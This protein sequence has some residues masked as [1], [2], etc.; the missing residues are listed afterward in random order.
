METIKDFIKD[1]AKSLIAICVNIALVAGIGYFIYSKVDAYIEKKT[2]ESAPVVLTP[3][4]AT[5]ANYLQNEEGLK[6]EDSKVVVLEV[7]KAQ[8]GVTTPN[9][10]ITVNSTSTKEAAEEVK[11][12]IANN[13][14]TLPA[15]A[16]EK[17]DKT[18]VSEQPE[19]QEYEVG[20]YKI[21]TYRNWGIGLGVGNMDGKTYIPIAIERQYSR[22]KSIEF[23]VNYDVSRS[24]IDGG[25]IVHKWHF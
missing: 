5:N 3:E 23:Q 2:N 21:N 14:S 25:Q 20:V 17:T 12:R 24:K 19:N 18:I 1:N 10:T 4:Q 8:S 22:D 11:E 9:T 15:E 16:L 13:D 6:K 7:A